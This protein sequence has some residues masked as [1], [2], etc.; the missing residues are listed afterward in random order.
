MK[1]NSFWKRMTFPLDY[2]SI[3]QCHH[4][5]L[6]W[7]DTRYVSPLPVVYTHLQTEYKT[8]LM[9]EFILDNAEKKIYWDSSRIL[10]AVERTTPVSSEQ[11][12][13]LR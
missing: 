2:H 6:Q 12:R 3:L 4:F 1:R 5:T 13:K 9:D 7:I 11:C 10:Q 8:T